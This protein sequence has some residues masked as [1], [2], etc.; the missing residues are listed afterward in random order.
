MTSTN[1]ARSVTAARVKPEQEAW[2]QALCAVPGLEVY[3]WRPG[4][5]DA[6]AEVLH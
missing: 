3:V 6:I 4:D 5:M 2:L 1:G